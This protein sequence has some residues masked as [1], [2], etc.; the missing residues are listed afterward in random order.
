MLPNEKREML[1]KILDQEFMSP[2]QLLNEVIIALDANEAKE[3]ALHI[4]RNYDLNLFKEL[5]N[6]L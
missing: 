1:Y 5:Q 4:D 3:I 6:E 2:M